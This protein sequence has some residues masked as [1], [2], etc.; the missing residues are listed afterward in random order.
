[1]N[2]SMN[3]HPLDAAIVVIYMVAVLAFG[4]WIGRGQRTPADYFLGS[5]SLPW[6]LLLLSIVATE[7]STVTFLSLP[8]LP[9]AADGNLTFLQIAI[10]YIAGRLLIIQV[11]LPIYFRADNFT[12]YEVLEARFGKLSR[13]LTSVLFLITRNLSDALRLFLTALVLQI[14]LGLDLTL[15]V[16]LLDTYLPDFVDG[17]R[18]GGARSVIWNDAI[19]FVIYM[20]GAFAAITVIVMNTPGGWPAL[21]EFAEQGDKFRLFD[22]DLGLTKPGMTFWSGV[23]GGAFLTMATHGTDQLMVQRYLSAKNQRGAALSLGFSGLV[24][25][26]QFAVFL[27]I[28]IALAGFYAQTPGANPLDGG[29][30]DRLFAHFI[31]N[32]MPLGLTGLTL[33]AVFAAAMSTLSSSLNS[34]ATALIS[35]LWLP[36]RKTAMPQ[37]AQLRAGRIATAGFGILQV[38]IATLVGVIGTTE[39]T[40][41]NVLKIAGFASGPVLGLFLLAVAGARVKQPA[42][43][44]GFGVGVAGLSIIAVGT[45]LYWPWY[46]AVGSILTW[47]AGWLIQ[48]ST[49]TALQR[50]NPPT[51]DRLA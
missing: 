5:R 33:A 16:I 48:L 30:G 9:A 13:R 47:L 44:M 40:V 15:S 28:G 45:D 3:I 46:A 35:D 39:S 22:F 19:Q 17:I 51:T 36:L 21:V 41:F 43:L 7:T 38:T 50:A 4:L 18:V 6:G 24:V 27:G 1:M 2:F 10:G 49:P 29:H 11:L 25:F 20:L 23:A 14:V 34:S 26:L 32:S 37:A 42:A 12:A 8:G 31:V